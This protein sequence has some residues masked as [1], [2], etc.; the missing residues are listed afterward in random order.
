MS[1]N[2]WLILTTALQ[3]SALS[4]SWLTRNEPGADPVYQQSAFSG[5]VITTAFVTGGI[6]YLLAGDKCDLAC[7]ITPNPKLRSDLALQTTGAN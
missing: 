5:F 1:A 2:G 3:L 7:C 4:G 6:H